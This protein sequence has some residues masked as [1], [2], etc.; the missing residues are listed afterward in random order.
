M[1]YK[2]S[3]VFWTVFCTCSKKTHN[4]AQETCIISVLP[5]LFL[6]FVGDSPQRHLRCL[7]FVVVVRRIKKTNNKKT[8]KKVWHVS[9]WACLF[10]MLASFPWQAKACHCAVTK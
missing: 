4:L 6:S 5:F 3:P 9:W 7:C 8:T 1:F 10:G 2:A